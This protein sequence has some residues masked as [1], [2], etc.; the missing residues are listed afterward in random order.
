MQSNWYTLT[1]EEIFKK[2]D[3]KERGLSAADAAKRREEYGANRLPEAKV[4]SVFIIFLRQFENPLIYILLIAGIVVLLMGEEIDAIVITAVLVFNA[5]IGA[6]QEGKAR[7]TLLALKQFVE[8]KA[9][10]MRDEKEI[11]VL[12]EEIVPGDIIVL[13][14]GEKVPADARLVLSNN[15]KVDEAALTGESEAVFKHVRPITKPDLAPPEQKNMVFKGTHV[16]AGNAL[17]IV[18]ATGVDT[19][20]GKIAKEVAEIDT[21]I[22]LKQN[23]KNLSR[24]FII[25]TV[26]ICVLLFILG[27]FKGYST[28]EMFATA[29]SVAVSAIP[30][31]LPIALTIILAS[32]VWRMGK[33]NA[34]VKRLQAV[35]ALGQARI[36]AVDKTGTITKNE[37]MVQ[38]VFTNGKSFEIGGVGYEPKG[39]I[40]MGDETVE[41]R[42]YQELMHIGKM[43]AF[44][45][46]AR[47]MYSEEKKEWRV[48]GDPTEAAMAVLAEK[49]GFNKVGLEQQAPL[50]AELPFD[51]AFKY[52]AT[53]HKGDGRQNFLTVVGAPEVVLSLAPKILGN[54]KVKKM[55]KAER[56]ELENMIVD[57]SRRGLR[58]LAIAQ[59]SVSGHELGREEINDLA[60]VGFF[61][62]RDALRPE[63]KDA[64]RS[65]QE[66]GLKVV[67][68]TGDHRET[69]TAIAREA[70]IFKE[71]DTILTGTEIE[72]MNEYELQAKL[73]RASVFA[74]VTPEHKLRIIRAYRAR[75]EIIAMTGDGVNDA[76]SLVAADL[77][78]GMG[79]VG[80]EVAKEASDIILLDDNFGSIVAAIEEGRGIYKTIKKVIVYLVSTSIGEALVIVSSL[81]IGLPLPLLAAQIIWLNFVTDGFFIPALAM[82]PKE[83]D[84][85]KAKFEKPNKYL[86]DTPMLRR[87]LLMATPMVI[88]SL[89]LFG[90]TYEADLARAMTLALTILCVFQW[91]NAWNSRSETESI[92]KMNPFENLWLIGGTIVAFVFQLLAVYHPFFQSFLR[93]VPLNL[94]DWLIVFALSLSII[95]VEEARKSLARRKKFSVASGRLSAVS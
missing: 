2:L 50:I 76:P 52:H 21:D 10:V 49:L 4:D 78:L 54:G 17:A 48:S 26:F 7:N 41:P 38:T 23:I 40:K 79:K 81:I 15:L 6:I 92:F 35:E 29:V 22:P 66:A 3:T 28:R 16:V 46:D 14:E 44:C 87:M 88:F 68:I 57:I 18:V 64:T 85:L 62:L 80:T 25:A 70:L 91:L 72:N 37:M 61:G 73:D 77:G 63:V 59:K 12:D 45:S 89:L 53:L 74:R 65:A 42:N 93:T 86:I 56:E 83:G 94:A 13:Q 60:F 32:G 36:I 33:R 19:V 43:A 51:Y 69:A 1:P 5:V 67:M 82:E 20:I 34:L 39:G 30:S 27:L 84:L 8:T 9:V 31:G 47:I 11:I 75:G 55:S 95:A 58:V 71:G 90:L 24:L